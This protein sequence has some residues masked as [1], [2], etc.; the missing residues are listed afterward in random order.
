MSI[1]LVLELIFA[2]YHNKRVGDLTNNSIR[3]ET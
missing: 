1:N 2:T 3:L